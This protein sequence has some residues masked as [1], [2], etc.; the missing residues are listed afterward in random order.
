MLSWQGTVRITYVTYDL[1]DA[2]VA[3]PSEARYAGMT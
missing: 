1:S 2:F 3:Q